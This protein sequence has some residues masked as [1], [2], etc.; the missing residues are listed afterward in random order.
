MDCE[1][2]AFPSLSLPLSFSLCLSFPLAVFVG[3]ENLLAH[4]RS[5]VTVKYNNITG[6]SRASV[7]FNL[8][9]SHLLPFL[10]NLRMSGR[11]NLPLHILI[12]KWHVFSE[13]ERLIMEQGCF[14]HFFMLPYM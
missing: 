9:C 8:N 14:C 12:L 6:S 1:I 13:D 4:K 7:F 10:P 5:A 11:F 2:R 3:Q